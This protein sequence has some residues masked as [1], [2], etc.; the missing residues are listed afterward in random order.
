MPWASRGI[1]FERKDS[2]DEVSLDGRISIPALYIAALIAKNTQNI[3]GSPTMAQHV[4]ALTAS[5]AQIAIDH[6]DL[7]IDSLV[8]KK[9]HLE[10]MKAE[11]SRLATENEEP[12]V[13][14]AY[15]SGSPSLNIYDATANMRVGKL[16]RIDRFIQVD[17][18]WA[19]RVGSNLKTKED[20]FR[21]TDSEDS[22][23]GVLSLH[24][25]I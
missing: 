3:N 17:P 10:E 1:F 7:L 13:Y 12:K 23:R 2:G 24:S 20:C 4:H 11:A 15:G 8:Q 6:L 5:E 21:F 16:R 19:A 18:V 25:L 22:A 9:I 14:Y